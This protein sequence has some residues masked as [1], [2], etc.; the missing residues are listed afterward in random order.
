MEDGGWDGG[1]AMHPIQMIE[2]LYK[3]GVRIG[4]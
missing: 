3:R 1:V 4:R 2:G